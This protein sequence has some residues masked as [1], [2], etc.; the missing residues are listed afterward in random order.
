MENR[1]VSALALGEGWHNYHH[2]F[3]WDY[4]AAEP[5]NYKLNVTIAVID[6]FALLGW[7]TDRKEPS[8]DLVKEIIKNRGDGSYPIDQEIPMPETNPLLS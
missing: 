8:P 1:V 5:G 6:F 3:P 2:V 7:V 4:K